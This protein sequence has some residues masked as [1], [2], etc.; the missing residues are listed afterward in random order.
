VPSVGPNP[1]AGVKNMSNFNDRII[2]AA[3]LDASV[4]EEVEEDTTALKQAMAVVVLSS[5]AAG[6][7][8]TTSGGLSVIMVI[9]TGT[10][11]ALIGWYI[12]A[13]I[14]YFIGTRLLPEPQTKADYGQLLRT[15]GF[16]SSPG[17]IRIFCIIPGLSG[18]ISVIAAVWMLVA[19]V[20]AVRQ[21]LDYRSTFRAVAVCIIGWVIQSLFLI[22]VLAIIGNLLK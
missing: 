12:W 3:K 11:L 2:R 22:V 5:I 21:A 14:T 8:T 6:I 10:I 20:V 19:M 13:Y 17:L 1:F 9:I 18:I 15:I 4:Y 16:S 7:G